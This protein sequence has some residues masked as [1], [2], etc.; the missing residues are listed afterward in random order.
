[1]PTITRPD[2]AEIAWEER[3]EGP[4]VIF[5]PVWLN[6]AAVFDA[7]LSDLATDQ[8][9]VSWDPR[10][11]G[12]STRSGPYDLETDIG[13]LEAV[14]EHCGG[15]VTLVE[16]TAP[17]SILLGAARPDLVRSV[18]ITATAPPLGS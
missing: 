12:G 14:V 5:S 16:L 9:V 1:M 15:D 11:T 8:R 6:W 13:D 3:G 4:L 10:G 17:R 7:L 18:V 2:G